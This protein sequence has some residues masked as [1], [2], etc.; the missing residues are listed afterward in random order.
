MQVDKIWI[1]SDRVDELDLGFYKTEETAFKAKK[2]MEEEADELG[3]T[4]PWLVIRG[5]FHVE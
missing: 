3:E 5:P 4:E 2:V 1:V